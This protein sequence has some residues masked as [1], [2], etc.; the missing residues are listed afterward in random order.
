MTREEIIEK[1]LEYFDENEDE[2]TEA[3]EEL[4]SYNGYLGD[5]RC[6]EMEYLDELFYGQ[7]V[8]FILQRAYF[9]HDDDDYSVD[10]LGDR[11]YGEF[12]PNRDYFYFN[13]YGNLVSTDYKDYTGYLDEW[14]AEKYLDVATEN[15]H[16][17]GFHSEELEELVEEWEVAE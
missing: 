1:V 12:N 17:W 16:Y 6:Y 15:P 5:D 4:D 9:G 2:F 13:G 7:D 3:I 11:H 10:S 14:F 8:L